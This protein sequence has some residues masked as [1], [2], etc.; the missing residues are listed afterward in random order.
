MEPKYPHIKVKLTGKDG[1]AFLIL[2]NVRQALRKNQVP[3]NEIEIFLKEAMSGDYNNL[4][5]ACMNWVDVS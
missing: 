3:Q 2:G 5:C 4:L 1:N